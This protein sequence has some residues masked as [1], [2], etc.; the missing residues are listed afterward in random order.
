MSE[1]RAAERILRLRADWDRGV[2]GLL[3]RFGNSV[4]SRQLLNLLRY[5]LAHNRI[6]VSRMPRAAACEAAGCQG[7]GLSRGCTGPTSRFRDGVGIRPR[8]VN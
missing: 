1:P 2:D 8:H 3:E 6:H 7:A 4:E 5:V